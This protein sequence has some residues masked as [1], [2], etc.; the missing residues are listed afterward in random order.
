MKIVQLHAENFKRLQAVE[1]TPKG[2][3]VTI[4]GKNGAGKSSV[5]DAI[6]VGLVGLSVAPPKP[7]RKGEE[8]AVIRIDM[9]DIVITRKFTEKDGKATASVKV[10]SAEGL[11]YP[12]PQAVLDALLG[13]I[14]FDPFAFVQMKGDAQAQTLLEMVP[15]PV[16]LDDLAESDRTDY[17]ARRDINRDVQALEGQIAGIAKE[18]VPEDIPDRAALVAALG[19]AADTNTTIERERLRRE[20]VR[21]EIEN[22]RTMTAEYKTKADEHLAEIQRLRDEAARMDAV[23]GE[24]E[25]QLDQLSALDEPVDTD[26]IRTKLHAADAADAILTRQTR[27]NNLVSD[28]TTKQEESRALTEAMAARDKQRND[29]LA[30]AQMPIDGLAFALDEKGKPVVMFGGVPF[31]QASSAEQLR[32]ST[33]IAM[34]ANPQLRVLRIKDGS[35]LDDDSMTMLAEMAEAEDFQLWIERVGTGGVGVVIEDG[36]VKADD[37][38]PEGEEK[39]K[40]A[41]KP[42]ATKDKPA[43]DNKPEGSLL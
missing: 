18:D 14:G 7:V 8:Q 4:S 24:M 3:V 28:L 20:G 16:D 35:L 29:A 10:Q 12:S 25:E 22:R 43:A 41:A 17:A 1:I 33:A 34:A 30:G 5:L 27:R 19:S 11:S 39:P 15:L 32:A 37:A 2:N 13:N 40:T 21:R 6:W 26:E 42:K 36:A 38:Q 31:E 23:T 9:G